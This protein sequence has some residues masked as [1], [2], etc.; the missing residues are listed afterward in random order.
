M[1]YND[2]QWTWNEKNGQLIQKINGTSRC[3]SVTP[4]TQPTQSQNPLFFYENFKEMT[5]AGFLSKTTVNIGKK[6]F[7]SRKLTEV[8]GRGRPAGCNEE[9]K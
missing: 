3:N 4:L 9:K 8:S 2:L 5:H 7:Q 1:N 6:K